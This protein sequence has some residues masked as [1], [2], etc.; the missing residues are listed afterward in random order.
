MQR[1]TYCCSNK[2]RQLKAIALRSGPVRPP[3]NQPSGHSNMNITVANLAY[4]DISGTACPSPIQAHKQP[5]APLHGSASTRSK[6]GG[7]K[8][9]Q[10]PRSSAMA[11]SSG[12]HAHHHA[13]SGHAATHVAAACG[14]QHLAADVRGVLSRQEHVAG[15]ARHGGGLAVHLHVR[16]CE[17][18]GR[19]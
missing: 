18:V 6:A 10:H 14:V 3:I 5:P 13:A 17:C 12:A 16:A 4:L 9:H 2:R 7:E 1:F 15:A 19:L 11:A 8:G